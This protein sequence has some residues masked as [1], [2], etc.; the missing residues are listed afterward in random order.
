[1]PA[2]PW[3]WLFPRTS[4]TRF[5]SWTS[6]ENV[7][8]LFL[9]LVGFAAEKPRL[10]VLLVSL[11]THVL[12]LFRLGPPACLFLPKPHLLRLSRLQGPAS[13]AISHSPKLLDH[14]IPNKAHTSAHVCIDTLN[15]MQ[16]MLCPSLEHRAV[17][18]LFDREVI[19]A[20]YKKMK[21]N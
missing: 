19:C 18:P 4:V 10:H 9:S 12:L 6:Y 8:M 7:H 17:C 5:K 21:L 3:L 15:R 11:P 2:S 13:T 1:M 20:R 16:H 14:R